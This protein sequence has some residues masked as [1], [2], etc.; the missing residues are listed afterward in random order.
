LPHRDGAKNERRAGIVTRQIDQR[1]PVLKAALSRDCLQPP[2]VARE[3]GREHQMSARCPDFDGL[4]VP[5]D[6]LRLPIRVF[7][8]NCQNPRRDHERQQNND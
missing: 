5:L 6:G 3:V 7:H 8:P 1:V 4:I 2:D